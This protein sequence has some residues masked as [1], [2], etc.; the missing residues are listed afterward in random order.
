[1]LARKA[2]NGLI[3][4]SG[5][6]TEQPPRYKWDGVT[7]CYTSHAF[8]ELAKLQDATGFKSDAAWNAYAADLAS[9]FN[10]LFW[11]SDHF[12]EYI[13]PEHGLV[14]SH[15]LSDVNWAAVAFGIATDEQL[16][17]LW[18]RLMEEK[19]FWYADMP[20]Q[21]VTKPFTYADWELNYGPPCPDPPLAD[22]AAMGR[23]WYLEAMACKQMKAH[24]R[25]IESVRKVYKARDA[26][27]FWRERYH[28]Q[29]DGTVKAEGAPKYCEY[30]SVLVRV[31]L[32]TPDVFCM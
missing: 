13:H 8:R 1:L 18:P 19:G 2:K 23:T 3:D 25:L 4:G 6:Y 20:T 11:R 27:G 10:T 7:Q 22:V 24:D 32:G 9:R 29:K 12:G 26:G 15:G 17:K 14:D 5:F 16:K 28:P 30:P 31:V 21:T